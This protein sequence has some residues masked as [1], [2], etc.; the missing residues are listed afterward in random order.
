MISQ[1][2]LFIL[3]G[4]F[5]LIGTYTFSQVSLYKS[6]EIEFKKQ[7]DKA[8]FIDLDKADLKD[9]LFAKFGEDFIQFIQ[10]N[11][12]T[13][14]Y[15]FKD[16]SAV[17]ISNSDDHQFRIYS[18]DDGMGGT[19]RNFNQLVQ[20]RSNGKVFTYIPKGEEDGAG[21]YCSEIYQIKVGDK[22][23]YLPI[24]FSIGSSR[25]HGQSISSYTVVN[26]TLTDTTRLFKTRTKFIK[27]I[28][29]YFTTDNYEDHKGEPI[30][31]I[32]KD[33]KN[34][35]LYIAIAKKDGALTPNNLIY[36]F[37]GRY[38]EFIGS[39]LKK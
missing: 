9:S 25:D 15:P 3:T 29:V 10:K 27:S 14:D 12:G 20:Y 16:I 7:Y 33:D 36:K 35:F 23:Y 11:P 39:D 38:F 18:W 13:L 31:F 8:Q 19:M 28:G 6:K 22:T 32:K 17:I 2:K 37:N 26:N 5:T 24:N 21:G 4:F 30:Q 34:I 1:T